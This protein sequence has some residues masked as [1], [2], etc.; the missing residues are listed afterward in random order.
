MMQRLV[1]CLCL[2][3]VAASA[4]S[5]NITLF[6]PSIFNGTELKLGD[7]RL[8]IKD[9]TVVLKRGKQSIEA[10]AKVETSDSKFSSTSV[11]YQNGDG[12]YRIQEIRLGGT[13][14]RLVFN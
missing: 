7:Y 13:K 11:R 3:A 8:E 6:Q 2:L 14:T 5:H 1:V 9:Q 10:A 4:A 12:K